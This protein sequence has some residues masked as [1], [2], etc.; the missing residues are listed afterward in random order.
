VAVQKR[1]TFETKT[2]RECNVKSILKELPEM[3]YECNAWFYN[4]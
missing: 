1:N 3:S 4:T 2:G